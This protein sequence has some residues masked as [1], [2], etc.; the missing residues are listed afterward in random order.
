MKTV[1]S[2]II[3]LVIVAYNCDVASSQIVISG[4]PVKDGTWEY[5]FDEMRGNKASTK[6]VEGGSELHYSIDPQN[7]GDLLMLLVHAPVR[8]ELGVS[9]EQVVALQRVL[10]QQRIE[11]KYIAGS[12]PPDL[13]RDHTKKVA[14]LEAQ[15]FDRVEVIEELL[16]PEQIDRL[17]EIARRAEIAFVGIDEALVTGFLGRD[18]GVLE[19]EEAK[20]RTRTRKIMAAANAEIA[21]I[22]DAAHKKVLAELSPDKRKRGED[23][24][25][26]PFYFVLP[27]GDSVPKRDFLDT[28]F[29][30]SFE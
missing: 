10:R 18:I 7:A 29:E 17:R 30:N 27:R 14:F 16:V 4:K 8:E 1:F 25:G 23:L 20:I 28:D 5:E 2:L 15:K 22:L 11:R 3:G 26:K 19:Q 24:L 13:Y 21:N 12:E 9:Q 6:M